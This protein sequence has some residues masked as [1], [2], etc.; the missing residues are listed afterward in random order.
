MPDAMT[1]VSELSEKL[2]ANS[3]SISAQMQAVIRNLQD[4]LVNP[5]EGLQ[6]GDVK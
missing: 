3:A 5:E 6:N 2:I 4:V 1:R